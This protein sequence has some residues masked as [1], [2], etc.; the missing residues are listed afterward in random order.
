[1]AKR[2]L[3]Q[4]EIQRALVESDDE[5]ISVRECDGDDEN[6]AVDSCSDSESNVTEPASENDDEQLWSESDDVPIQEYVSIDTYEGRDGTTWKS[7]LDRQSR[8]PRHNII[9]GGIHKVILPPGQAI[10]DPIDSFSLFFDDHVLEIIVKYT[11]TEGLR[12]LQN[13][14]K[15]TDKIEMQAFLGLLLTISVN[16]QRGVDFREYWDPIFGNPIFRATMGKNRFA[17]LLRFLRFDDKNTRSLR[18]SKDKLAPIRELWEY[19]NQNLK[20]FYLPGENLTI[21]EQL[22]PFRG[23]VSFKQYLPSKPDKHGMKIWWMCDSKT[24]Y[25]LF[26]I[27]YLGKEGQNRAESLAYNVLN[28]LCEPNIR[29]NRNVT[30]DNY[31]T[32]IDVAKSLAQNGLTIV[33]TLRKNKTCIPPNFQPKKTRD[34][35]SNVFGFYKNM[36]LV[37][38][39]PKKNHALILLST[40]HHG[41]DEDVNKNNKSEINLYYNSTK[42]GVDTLDQMVHEYTVRRKTNRWPIAFFQNIIDVVGIA[43]LIIWKNI[44]PDWN[45]RK[46]NTL[47]KLFLREIATELVTPHIRRR[48][49]KGLSSY[50]LSGLMMELPNFQLCYQTLKANHG[51]SVFHENINKSKHS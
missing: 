41:K 12:I 19:V 50:H 44:H 32:S 4:S 5:N 7:E 25:P 9:R 3:A 24:S 31:F 21:D 43:S 37:S 28:Q 2:Q 40:M 8:T 33:G 36:T 16:K 10:I 17:S 1:M 45:S 29:S 26:G 23:R 35:E 15:S 13:R 18:K 48:S 46:K 34:I 20:K 42:G 27:P 14:W 47:R 11:N 38:Y 49:T 39:V 51:Q 6:F 22:V 30:F